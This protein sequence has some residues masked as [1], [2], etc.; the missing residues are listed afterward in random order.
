MVSIEYTHFYRIREE[1][2]SEGEGGLGCRLPPPS[3]HSSEYMIVCVHDALESKQH[4]VISVIPH[5]L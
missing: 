4:A 5:D 2:G 1:G 3:H